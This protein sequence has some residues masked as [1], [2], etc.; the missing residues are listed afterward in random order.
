MVRMVTFTNWLCLWIKVE[1]TQ[2]KLAEAKEGGARI[3][4]LG[5]F[6]DGEPDYRDCGIGADQ[7]RENSG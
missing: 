6:E 7:E 1:R 2:A 4:Q 5:F 3:A